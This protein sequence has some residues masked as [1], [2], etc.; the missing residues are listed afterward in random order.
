MERPKL[1]DIPGTD[2]AYI[3]EACG[4]DENGFDGW[5][6]TTRERT[7]KWDKPTRESID[8]KRILNNYAMK[9][10]IKEGR[11]LDEVAE[12]ISSKNNDGHLPR[13]HLV[14]DMFFSPVNQELTPD[15]N[16]NLLLKSHGSQLENIK[17]DGGDVLI[18]CKGNIL[19][20]TKGHMFIYSLEQK[21]TPEGVVD[22]GYY[23]TAVFTAKNDY[24]RNTTDITSIEYNFLTPKG[25]LIS[26]THFDKTDRPT[27]VPV[28]RV[29]RDDRGS[30]LFIDKDILP[31]GYVYTDSSE[32]MFFPTPSALL[33]ANRTRIGEN[34]NLP[35]LL[36]NE[37]AIIVDL[38]ERELQIPRI[39]AKLT[40]KCSKGFKSQKG[41]ISYETYRDA[42]KS[43]NEEAELS[44]IFRKNFET[45]HDRAIEESLSIGA[46]QEMDEM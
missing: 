42:I 15:A 33:I 44:N 22:F 6:R 23:K 26:R 41:G 43:M 32:V 12:A 34:P 36:K 45:A 25:N 16:G 3:I 37:N 27:L 29:Y 1:R 7:L 35:P 19:R 5:I 20:N 9:I 17:I 24:V 10:Y 28:E 14:G 11:S 21:N 18:D 40:E 46:E 4:R 2:L 8:D 31:T 30:S 39:Q 13:P 38:Y